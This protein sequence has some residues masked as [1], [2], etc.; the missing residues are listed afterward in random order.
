VFALKKKQSKIN[1][2]WTGLLNVQTKNHL[3]TKW[4]SHT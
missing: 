1:S 2:S 4:Y 3:S